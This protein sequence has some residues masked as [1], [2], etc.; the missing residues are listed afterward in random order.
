VKQRPVSRSFDALASATAAFHRGDFDF[1]LRAVEAQQPTTKTHCLR[2]SIL[3]RMN[4][5]AEAHDAAEWAVAAAQDDEDCVLA[6]CNMAT[7]LSVLKRPEE[8][9]AAIAE[10]DD[11]RYRVS[12]FARGR[13][14]F[15]RALMAWGA[16]DAETAE[17]EMLEAYRCS[18]PHER[19]CAYQLHA[20]VSFLR[21]EHDKACEMLVMALAEHDKAPSAPWEAQI[22]S[23]ISFLS[24]ELATKVN[25]NDMRRRLRALPWAPGLHEHRFWAHRNFG[26]RLVTDGGLSVQVGI[27][28]LRQGQDFAVTAAQKALSTLDSAQ[29][30]F[31]VEE[32][33]HAEAFLSQGVELLGKIDWTQ[34]SGDERFS[35][36][37]AAELCAPKKPEE[38]ARLLETFR[39]LPPM[40][41][42]QAFSHGNRL[43]AM[44]AHAE[45]VVARWNG[46]KE[47]AVE[48]FSFALEAFEAIRYKWRASEAALEL[49]LLTGN[50][51]YRARG[52]ELLNDDYP[53]SW[54]RLLLRAGN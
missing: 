33:E 35:L 40:G 13:V 52:E 27:V 17:S 38:A 6:A 23:N 10:A 37:T 14:G 3:R 34:E 42:L 22:I 26:L 41:Y 15:T 49:H 28:F 32:R 24:S 39:A 12:D 31:H 43:P 1:A 8:A 25:L 4:R 18:E 21:E 30:A 46:D 19:M 16:G 44:I 9:V 7:S 11:L 51:L 5:I 54:L 2:S 20:F 47:R 50:A 53:E 48:R 36:L 29:A 45:G